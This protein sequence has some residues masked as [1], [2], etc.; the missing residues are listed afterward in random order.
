MANSLKIA[1][2]RESEYH[3]KYYSDHSL[4]EPGTWLAGPAQYAMRSL[5]YIHTTSPDLLDLGCGVGRHAFP[6]LSRLGNGATVVGVD[7]LP[8]AI[9]IFQKNAVHAGVAGRISYD[10]ADVAEYNYGL[11]RFDLIL[12]VSCIEHVSSF[13]ELRQILAKIQSATRR[14]G[15]NCFMISTDIEWYDEKNDKH[16]PPII[17]FP[18]NSTDLVVLLKDLYVSW[19]IVD[20]SKK[21]WSVA[22]I[23]DGEAIVNRSTCVQ[24]TAVRPE[25]E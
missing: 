25:E 10:V 23:I 3:T 4:G 19:D 12:S 17:E 2:A 24:F 18:L 13:D 21:Q 14:G 20:L 8:E 5:S 6:M 16:I 15:V 22:D 11:E 7:M 1:R 9:E